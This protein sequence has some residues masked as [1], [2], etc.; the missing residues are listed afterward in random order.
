MHTTALAGAPY[1]S[2]GAAVQAGAAYAYLV[3]PAPAP[4]PAISRLSPA[5][6]RRGATVT[7]IGTAFGAR[8]VKSS[9]AFGSK[10]CT[11]YV[12]W[13]ATRIKCKVPA[14]AA[15]GAQKVRVT[16]TAGKSGAKPF[17]VKR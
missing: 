7:I 12:S 6:G 17:K 10:K 3:E 5:S 16:T 13:S 1:H 14:K 9:V 2:L 8:Q 4:K 15:F 11:R